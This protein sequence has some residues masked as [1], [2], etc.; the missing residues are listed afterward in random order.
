M[1]F[2]LCYVFFARHTIGH[3]SDIQYVKLVKEIGPMFRLTVRMQDVVNNTS[4]NN[5]K[6]KVMCTV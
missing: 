4:E 2:C 1:Q 5:N 3:R 6:N